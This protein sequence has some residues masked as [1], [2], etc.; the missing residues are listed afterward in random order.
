IVL[1]LNGTINT[2]FADPEFRKRW[3]AIGTPVVGG[4]PEAFG[5]LIRSETTRL[6]K[7]VHE[8]GATVD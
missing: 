7:I 2:I 8:T 1:K 5:T 6:G 4:T 3:E